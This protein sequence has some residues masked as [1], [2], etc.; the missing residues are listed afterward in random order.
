[1][2]VRIGFDLDG[3]LADFAAAYRAVDEQLHGSGSVPTRPG[4][5]EDE[6][7]DEQQP[8]RPRPSPRRRHD[9]V[10]QAIVATPDFWTSLKP[11]EEGVVAR[12]S[13]VT[14]RLQWEVFF[15]TQRPATAGE[16]VQRQSQRWL[17]A[18][19]F[20]LPSVLVISGSRGAAAAA[21]SLDYH[22]DDNAKNCIDVKAASGARPLLIADPADEAVSS[23][24]R[25]L[26]V[27]LVPSVT[28]AI[29][30]LEQA[31]QA[32]EEP[33]LFEKVARLVGWV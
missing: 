33:S 19:G 13:E 7:H 26:G 16:T 28:A 15:I 12:L 23:S 10:W 32:R 4:D 14:S 8:A 1:M 29:D 6:A 9:A 25:R 5:P 20:D 30:V 17:A 2:P 11:M 3:V 18:Q 31:T 27:G 21:L 24:A 22:V